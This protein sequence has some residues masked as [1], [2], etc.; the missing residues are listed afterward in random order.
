MT[1]GIDRRKM[2]R[3]VAVGAGLVWSA[4]A[5]KSVRLLAAPGTPAPPTSDTEPPMF[6]TYTF[7]GPFKATFVFLPPEPGCGS[8]GEFD[9]PTN[10]DGV[11]PA[12]VAENICVNNGGGPVVLLSGSFML[13][14][15]G[16]T[17]VGTFTGTAGPPDG[18]GAPAHH[19][20][21]ITSGTGI[22][23]GATGT[24][25]LDGTPG[26]SQFPVVQGTLSGSVTVPG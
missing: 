4:P 14:V 16:G 10:V 8:N 17:L 12:T 23:A 21:T 6:T 24:A 20:I 13:T 3:G 15:N 11:G 1:E 25:T 18:S 9:F 22:F 19:D 2:L 26:P 5:V 7:G